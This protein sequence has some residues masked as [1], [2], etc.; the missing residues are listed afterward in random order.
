MKV[1]RIENPITGIGPYNDSMGNDELIK[2]L[3]EAHNGDWM[4][5]ILRADCGTWYSP[6]PYLSA[7]PSIDKL[8]EWFDGFLPKMQKAGYKIYQISVCRGWKKSKSGYQIGILP[9]YIVS[10]KEVPFP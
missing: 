10:K 1:Y 6:R 9:E 5:P 3:R 8:K 4:H 2:E 7:C